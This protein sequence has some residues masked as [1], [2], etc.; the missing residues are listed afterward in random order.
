MI[1]LTLF[2][3]LFK[4][5]LFTFGGGYAMLPLIQAEVLGNNWLSTDDFI[6]FIAVSESTPGPFAVNIAT[7]IGTK[8]GE[9]SG[10]LGGI[11]GAFCATLG[12][13]LPSFIIILIVAT[14]FE[15]FKES[16]I[17]KGCMSGLKP[18]TVG[19]IA[20]AIISIAINAFFHDSFSVKAM[21]DISFIISMGIFLIMAFLTFKKKMHP[22]IIILLSAVLGIIV[23]YL[24]M[25]I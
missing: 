14:C 3:T 20:S 15:K 8:M 18:A 5:G 21:T 4:I 25:L 13:V 22:I 2:L 12:V 7:Y 17:I 11:F 23:G 10:I 16:K 19:L 24:K 6:N 9:A 1:Y